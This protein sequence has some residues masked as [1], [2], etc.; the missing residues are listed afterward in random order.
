MKI[1][2]CEDDIVTMKAIQVAFENENVELV[3]VKDGLMALEQ[4]RE[5][6]FDLIITDIHMPFHNGDDIIS[7]VREEQG[8]NTPIVVISSDAQEEVIQLALRQ[9]VNEFIKK[10]V[11]PVNLQRKVLKFLRF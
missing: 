1:L 5:N 9:G 11:D 3:S 6:T 4:L 7:L 10:P 2:I 8:K